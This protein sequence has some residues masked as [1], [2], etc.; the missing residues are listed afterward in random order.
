MSASIL[1]LSLKFFTDHH[2]TSSALTESPNKLLHSSPR[3][4]SHFLYHLNHSPPLYLVS[5]P[6]NFH[7]PEF[8]YDREAPFWVGPYPHRHTRPP[9][10][11]ESS[12][13]HL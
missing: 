12:Q 8:R 11:H 2:P 4:R 6:R 1:I 13:D 10:D 3:P 7:T 5:W 9:P